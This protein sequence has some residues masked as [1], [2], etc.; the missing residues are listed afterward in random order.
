VGHNLT[1]IIRGWAGGESPGKGT[2]PETASVRGNRR[3][4]KKRQKREYLGVKS[5]S[6]GGRCALSVREIRG[7][8]K[9]K[10]LATSGQKENG[11][12]KDLCDNYLDERRG[13]GA[14][15]SSLTGTG[16]NNQKVRNAQRAVKK[17][18]ARG[19]E[20]RGWRAGTTQGEH[21]Y[22]EGDPHL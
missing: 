11:T 8:R 21:Q 17:V 15:I 19:E 1:S 14:D 12:W 18:L 10:S 7:T 16:G 22:Y 13:G 6:P 5:N 3:R 2:A 9:E 20:K 4:T